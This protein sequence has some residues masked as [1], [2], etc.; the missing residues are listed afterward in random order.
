MVHDLDDVTVTKSAEGVV[1]WLPDGSSAEVAEGT[2]RRSAMLQEAIQTGGKAIEMS[3]TVPQGI[4]LDWLH[5][6]DALKAAS[7]TTGQGT[8]LAR[9]THLLQFLRVRRFPLCRRGWFTHS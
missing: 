8:V 9:N 3:I 6:V 4:L 1:L 5:S 2:M 7:T